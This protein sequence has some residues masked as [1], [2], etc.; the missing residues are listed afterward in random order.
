M[1]VKLILK[2]FFKSF[3]CFLLSILITFSGAAPTFAKVKLPSG[4]DDEFSENN[5]VFYNPNGKTGDDNCPPTQGTIDSKDVLIIGDSITNGSSSELKNELPDA[6]IIAQDSKH[7]SHDVSGNESG[8]TILKNMNADSMKK[9]IV[10]ALGTNDQGG[11]SSSDIDAVLDVIGSDRT[12]VLVTNHKLNSP[13][14][15]NT[16]NT[17]FKSAASSHSNVAVADWAAAVKDDDD[18]YITNADGLG[19]HPTAEGKKKFAEVIASTLKSG[20]SS[21]GGGS[22][23]ANNK[24]YDGTPVF[25]DSELQTIESNRSFYESAANK[26]NIPW[27]ILAVVHYRET[28]LSR[29]NPSNGQGVYQHLNKYYAPGPIT[30]TEFQEQTDYTAQQIRDV[31]ASGLDLSDDNNIKLMFFRYNGTAEAYKSQARSLGFSEEEAN[32]GEGS[33]YVM[34]KADEKRD[35][36]KNPN[37]WGQ[38]KRD[39]GGIEYPANQDPGAYIMYRAI[40]GGT[41]TSCGGGNGD[42]NK[43]ALELAWPF[44]EKGMHDKYDPRPTYTTALAAVGLNTYDDEWVKIGAS[45]DAYVATVLRYS[46]VD[47]DFVCCGASNVLNYLQTSGK[48]EEVPNDASSLK[49]GDIRASSGHVE[50]YVDDNGTGRIASASHGDRTAEVGNYYDNSSTFKAFRF[51]GGGSELH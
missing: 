6:E 18:A 28:R 1:K 37:G 4:R 23:G 30:D 3:S 50:L 48:Y 43:T 7:F 39:H 32:R 31:Y 49:G 35:P 21:S 42:I 16:N 36:N 20:G 47:P 41:G 10:F 11:V 45:C 14:T 9:T 44:A 29:I 25:T 12:L 40:G 22:V 24:L 33:P 2:N 46:G 26:Y 5:I 27:Q 8:L 51:K 34:N 19:V 17:N 15:Y 13:N 38:I